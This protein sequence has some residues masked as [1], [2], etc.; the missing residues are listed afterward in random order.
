MSFPFNGQKGL[1]L[2]DVEVTGPLGTAPVNL[3]LDTGATYSIINSPTLVALGFDPAL[4]PNRLPVTTGSGIVVVPRIPL[5]KITAL[6]QDRL[7]FPVLCHT[8]PPSAGIDGLLGLDFFRG[9]EL[10]LDFNAGQ[11]TLTLSRVPETPAAQY[12]QNTSLSGFHSFLL[13][14]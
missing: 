2:V 11:I 8:L 4:F 7:G 10:T 3:A 6:G 9:R 1:V 12:G 5:L 13:P 14:Q